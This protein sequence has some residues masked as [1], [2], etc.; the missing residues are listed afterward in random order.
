MPFA[1]LHIAKICS[2]E[3]FFFSI[4][5]LES[6]KYELLNKSKGQSPQTLYY[7][8][9]AYKMETPKV[10]RSL[11]LYLPIR[12]ELH[13]CIALLSYGFAKLEIYFKK[14]QTKANI[15]LK[16]SGSTYVFLFHTDR[17]ENYENK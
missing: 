4:G 13:L 15:V 16:L 14:I 12:W 5:I 10:V 2:L 7:K 3:I 17:K 6:L 1:F 8:K 9:R 11:C